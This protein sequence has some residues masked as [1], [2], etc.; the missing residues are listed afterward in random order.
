M[1]KFKLKKFWQ[2]I[3]CILT[4]IIW[5]QYISSY[6]FFFWGMKDF[7]VFFAIAAYMIKFVYLILPGII[8]FIGI[9]QCVAQ[10]K[11]KTIYIILIILNSLY[12]TLLLLNKYDFSKFLY[13]DLYFIIKNIFID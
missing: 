5:T 13:P 11:L 12:Y 2:I 3:F 1:E 6:I 10:K 8:I 7:D 9:L 4:V